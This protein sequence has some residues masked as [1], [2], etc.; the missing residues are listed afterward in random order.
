MSVALPRS[1]QETIDA[2]FLNERVG[3][4]LALEI[5]RRNVSPAEKHRRR[6]KRRLAA[7]IVAVVRDDDARREPPQQ[8]SLTG[9]ERRAHRRDDARHAGM[10]DGDG[11]E[12]AF[13]ENGAVDPPHR[14]LRSMQ[15]VQEPR[16]VED[17]RLRRVEVLR[18]AAVERASAESDQRAALVVNRNH[19]PVAEA[20]VVAVAC[21]C[22]A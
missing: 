7:G 22:A 9:R 19:Q 13:D 3:I 8:R 17:L 6:A 12:I 16:F 21:L 15:V 1:F 5:E 2:M 4:F 11:V 10:I 20:I 18:I 14:V